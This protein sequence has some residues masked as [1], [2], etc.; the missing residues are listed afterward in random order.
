M[1]L[2]DT[3]SPLGIPSHL[4]AAARALRME[5]GARALIEQLHAEGV[6]PILLKGPVTTRWLYGGLAS[7][8]PAGDIDILVSPADIGRTERVLSEAGF[9]HPPLDDIPGDKPWHAHAWQHPESGLEIDLHRTLI[10]VGVEPEVVWRVLNRHT[11]PFDLRGLEVPTLDEQARAL[12]VALHAAQEGPVGFKALEDLRRALE[13]GEDIWRRARSVGQE[14]DALGAMSAGMRLL[15][16]GAEL[17]DLMELPRQV[18]IPVALMSS[19][20]P[21]EA[22]GLA[23]L[24]ATPRW[25]AKFALVF[26]KTF[27]PREF[28]DSWYPPQQRGRWGLPGAYI[29][30]IRWLATRLPP[31]IRAWHRARTEGRFL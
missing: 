2:T 14:L 17:A 18:P 26:R 9:V 30:R 8:R 31:A 19:S 4:G 1:D 23:W 29:Y 15:P 25:R 24:L 16:P 11:E 27:P 10:G 20:A 12:H 7:A 13:V 21:S 3:S 22:I 6:E 5:I 28:M